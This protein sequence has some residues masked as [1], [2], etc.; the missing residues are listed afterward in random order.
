MQ[1]KFKSSFALFFTILLS[2][3]ILAPAI[4]QDPDETAE[5]PNLDD[6]VIQDSVT[7]GTRVEGRSSTET[8]VP[9]DVISGEALEKVGYVDLGEALQLV[10][11]SF[12]LSRTQ[13]SDGSDLFRPA[14]L[15]GL[16]PDQ[17]L[18]LINGKRRHTQ[19][20]LSLANT[21]GEGAAG[22]DVNSIPI[23]AVESI[24]VLRDGAA[25][26]YGSDAIAG[27]I[28]II[29][30]SS[31][32]ETHLNT[33]AGNYKE[34]D[35]DTFNVSLNTGFEIGDEGFLNLTGEFREADSTNR[36]DGS[37]FA[38]G[39][40]RFQAGEA[41][42]EFSSMFYNLEVP[43]SESTDFYSFGGFSNRDALGAGFFRRVDQADRA[44]PQVY[45]VGFLPRIANEASDFSI[46]AGIQH[47]FEGGW[48]LDVSAV[49]GSNEYSFGSVNT[50]NASI[51]GEYLANNPGASDADI[52]ANAG[53]REG[54]SGEIEFEQLTLNID[55]SGELDWGWNDVIYS[56]YGI[57][58]RDESYSLD[59][60]ELASYSCGASSPLLIEIPSV[61][62]PGTLANC[63]FQA[64][65]GLRPET[66]T[67]TGRDSLALYADFESNLTDRFLLGVA[68]RYEDYGDIGDNTSG[69]VSFRFEAS[70]DFALRGALS[71]GFRAPS[72]QQMSYSAVTTNLGGGGL[73]QS[74]LSPVGSPLP[75]ALGINNLGLE[76]SQST[77]LGFVW[78]VTDRLLVTVDAYQVD[79]DDRIILGGFLTE[80]A[81][82]S[83]GLNQAADALAASGVQQANFFSNGINT[84]TDGLE[85]VADYNTAAMGGYLGIT[86]ALSFNDTE[87]QDVNAPNGVDEDVILT[88]A[89]RT[90][91]ELGQPSERATFTLD[92]GNEKV[93]FLS[94]VSYFGE[95]Q[96]AWFTA[97]GNGIPA[98][99]AEFF[100][101]DTSPTHVIDAAALVDLEIGY[102]FSDH[103]KVTLGANNVF[104]QTPDELANND[105]QRAITEPF[106][107]APGGGTQTFG[108][109]RYP[110][111]A[112][113]Y[114]FNGAFYYLKAGFTF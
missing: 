18:V 2:F 33:M 79:I 101:V 37:P 78:D 76:S 82:R 56:A 66:A 39:Q 19:A 5:E 106:P 29:L 54:H 25:A 97:L 83:S 98:S 84:Q 7:V 13:I 73:T 41:E 107:A 27:V 114:G 113:S 63:G 95:T 111:R 71:T 47:E 30:K 17:V 48:A 60:G 52:A 112:V 92:W 28:N 22:T 6:I 74:L 90:G 49:L 81:L 34:G 93:S 12:N 77:S 16:Q 55:L 100:Q 104:D 20:L 61:S 103:I 53:P 40:V 105:F 102:K 46:A 21:I 43:I 35:G 64:F 70:E 62:N 38:G 15:R 67:D 94:R 50:I 75:V 4:A 45:P 10:A 51:A 58:Y 31:T 32:G 72:L 85:L 3:W 80:G 69:K 96:E 42:R 24:E 23:A 14:T 8:T 109:F 57:E 91:I 99:V 26:Q 89:S 11:P 108:G 87:V 88:D 59:P 1:P 9:I 110:L 86:F 44:V 68:A 65:P 36:A